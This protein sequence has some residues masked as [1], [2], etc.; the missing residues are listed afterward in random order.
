[1]LRLQQR[2]RNLVGP[3]FPHEA[4]GLPAVLMDG[5]VEVGIFEVYRHHPVPLL[6]GQQD[7]FRGLHLDFVLGTNWLRG[8]RSM[9]GL[10]PPVDFGTMNILL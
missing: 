2:D 10:Q 3:A 7:S 4:W 9:K 6:K 8:L 5:D 1:M